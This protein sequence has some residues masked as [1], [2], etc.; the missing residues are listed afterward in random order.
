VYCFFLPFLFG[1]DTLQSGQLIMLLDW[2]KQQFGV[3]RQAR[4]LLHL[5]GLVWKKVLLEKFLEQ[6]FVLIGI[7]FRNIHPP[8]GPSSHNKGLSFGSLALP[9]L[10]SSPALRQHFVQAV[11]STGGIEIGQSNE[12]AKARGEVQKLIYYFYFLTCCVSRF[13]RFIHPALVSCAPH[14]SRDGHRLHK[15]QAAGTAQPFS[16]CVWSTGHRASRCGKVRMN[17]RATT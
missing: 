4:C 2:R 12:G 16:A 15:V 1:L 5:F 8:K 6:I 14:T 11:Q 17:K 10:C 13:P 9:K 7:L 3:L